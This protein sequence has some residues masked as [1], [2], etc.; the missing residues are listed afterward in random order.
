MLADAKARSH[1]GFCG[2]FAG[3][4]EGTRFDP[5]FDFRRDVVLEP[6][7]RHADIGHTLRKT[8]GFRRRN[9]GVP[10][11]ENRL[12]PPSVDAL[13]RG[14]LPAGALAGSSR[15]AAGEPGYLAGVAFVD[16]VVARSG[17]D[18]ADHGP[19]ILRPPDRRLA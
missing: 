8:P 9:L 1:R 19:S 11:P 17:W 14:G 18:P 13:R 16:A 15:L 12:S 7:D 2:G 10:A 6:D 5:P 4:D 3:A